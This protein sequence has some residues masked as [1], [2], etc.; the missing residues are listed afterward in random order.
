M[1]TIIE[2]DPSKDYI[3]ETFISGDLSET[4]DTPVSEWETRMK[5]TLSKPRIV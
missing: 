4:V 3:R 1:K 2:V 5:E